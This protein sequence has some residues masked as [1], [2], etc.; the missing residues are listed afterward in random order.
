[1][2]DLAE[3]KFTAS[4]RESRVDVPRNLASTCIQYRLTA[5]LVASAYSFIHTHIYI[6]SILRVYAR[7]IHYN[8][9]QYTWLGT[10]HGRFHAPL[11]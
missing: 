4:T 3:R 8:I 7:V 1:M 2:L 5:N 10:G 11:T 6:H 9:I